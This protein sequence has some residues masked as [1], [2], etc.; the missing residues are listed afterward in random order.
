MPVFPKDVGV[1]IFRNIILKSQT[2][3]FGKEFVM[4]C[5]FHPEAEAVTTCAVCGAGIC[6]A[7]DAGAFA[8]L[9]KKRTA[10]VHRMRF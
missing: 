5:K 2:N 4:N 10:V 3:V 1:R 7:C 8:R 6:S 9:E